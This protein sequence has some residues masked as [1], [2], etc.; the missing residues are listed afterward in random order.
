[1]I[2][3]IQRCQGTDINLILALVG[4]RVGH[5]VIQAVNSF[6]DQNI[7][8]S[9]LFEIAAV[10]TLADLKVKGWKLDSL[11]GEQLHHIVVEL[12]HIQSFQT[13]EIIVPVLVPGRLLA[14]HKIIVQS[15]RM[16]Y[17]SQRPKLDG[18]P[19]G[20][21]GLTRGGGSCNHNELH[22]PAT[23]NI[24]CDLTDLTLLLGLL[25]QNQVIHGISA[26]LVIQI[27]DGLDS[28]LRPPLLGSLHCCK[29]LLSV[30]EGSNH[31]R[32]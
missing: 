4:Q 10:L 14:I 20:K 18:Q 19:V 1:M 16:R 21:A 6:D 31:I 29:Q 12:L 15:N 25:H 22:I 30:L 32:I 24:L 23:D 17:L 5:L 27:A 26:H 11:S 28:G 2:I 9:K 8:L 3:N 13:L 7:V